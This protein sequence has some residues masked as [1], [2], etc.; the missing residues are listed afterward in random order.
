LIENN[1]LGNFE[2][3]SFCLRI[4]GKLIQFLLDEHPASHIFF[5]EVTSSDE[6]ALPSGKFCNTLHTVQSLPQIY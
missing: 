1:T 6:D 2:I 3:Y 5:D 4:A